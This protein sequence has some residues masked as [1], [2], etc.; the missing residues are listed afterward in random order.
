MLDH[1]FKTG[2]GETM[3]HIVVRTLEQVTLH[4]T[5]LGVISCLPPIQQKGSKSVCAFGDSGCA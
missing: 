4:Y 2:E 1:N 3:C 5:F